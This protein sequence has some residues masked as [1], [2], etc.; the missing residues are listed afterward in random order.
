MT[1]LGGVHHF[2]GPLWGAIAFILLED[3]L[4][5]ITESWWL[6]FAPIVIVFALASPEGIQGL[7]FRLLGRAGLDAD[8]AGHSAAPGAYRAVRTAARRSSIADKPIA[9][10]ARPAQALRLAGG[11][12]GHRPGGASV[13]AAQPDRPERRRQDD[14]L[15]HAHRHVAR[16]ARARSIST[17]RTSRSLPVHR[18]HPP[19]PEPVVPDPQRVPQPDRVRER[20]HRGAGAASARHWHCG[21]TPTR[22]TTSTRAPGRCWT[23]SDW[24]T[25]PPNRAPTCRMASSACWRSRSRWPRMQGCC[26][27][28]NR[29]RD[30]PKPIARW[31]AR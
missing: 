9:D 16:R 7:V 30:W 13:P 14:V 22:S 24:R 12:A 19:G 4:S 29:W 2:L 6:M 1:V 25:V 8:A 3:R 11:G 10:G 28:T 26:C 23:R 31:S 20:A 21:A 18:A 17:A 5:A 27:W 15:Q